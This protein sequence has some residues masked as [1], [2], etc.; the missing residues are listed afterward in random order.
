MGGQTLFG[1]FI[2]GILHRGLMIRP[3]TIRGEFVR[4]V[5]K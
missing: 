5:P 3:I 1:E 2:G 4:E